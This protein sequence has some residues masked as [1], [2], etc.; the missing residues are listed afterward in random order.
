MFKKG[1]DG[2]MQN[3]T[4]QKDGDG[5][6]RWT[7]EGLWMLFV[8]SDTNFQGKAGKGGDLGRIVPKKGEKLK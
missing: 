1:L 3:K 8:E 2:G 5:A 6:N 7:E 4:G